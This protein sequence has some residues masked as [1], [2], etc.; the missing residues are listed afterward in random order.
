VVERQ[1]RRAGLLTTSIK[2]LGWQARVRL[3]LAG[4]RTAHHVSG[5]RVAALQRLA[6]SEAAAVLR[7]RVSV[8]RQLRQR[9]APEL[10]RH[11]ARFLDHEYGR[12]GV[13]LE[14]R[15]RLEVDRAVRLTQQVMDARD[16][17]LARLD[18][19]RNTEAL[20]RD[21]ALQRHAATLAHIETSKT[22]VWAHMDAADD[23]MEVV[24]HLTFRRYVAGLIGL[25]RSAGA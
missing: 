10:P 2:G 9:D 3:W 21:R 22:R 16:V 18:R 14:R 25:D 4:V 12:A 5:A 11:L 24:R 6:P 8:E 17:E 19:R 13:R 1:L 7:W 23:R 20:R 15:R